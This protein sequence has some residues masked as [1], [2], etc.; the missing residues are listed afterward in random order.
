MDKK[1]IVVFLLGWMFAFVFP[2]ARVIALFAG[3]RSS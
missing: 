3:K 1:V 2:P